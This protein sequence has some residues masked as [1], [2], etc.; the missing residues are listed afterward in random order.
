MLLAD[1]QAPT[2]WPSERAGP[3]NAS[4]HHSG[5]PTSVAT[6]LTHQKLAV[7]PPYSGGLE[8]AFFLHQKPGLLADLPWLA[9]SPILIPS[10]DPLQRKEKKKAALPA[11]PRISS[12]RI[13]HRCFFFYLF[14]HSLRT[15]TTTRSKRTHAIP[16]RWCT[17]SGR[18]PSSGPAV[19]SPSYVFSHVRGSE[20]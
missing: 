1:D 15:R 5:G 8:E 19:L 14:S 2:M 6:F 12:P 9:S 3:E 13:G 17:V 11:P 20:D 7:H 16:G 18:G 10:D 4:P